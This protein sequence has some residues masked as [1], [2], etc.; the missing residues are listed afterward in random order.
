MQ[1]KPRKDALPALTVS[2]ISFILW[3][4]LGLRFAAAAPSNAPVFE[5]IPGF[6]ALPLSEVGRY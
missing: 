5:E 2:A 3:L 6:E 4:C 1:K